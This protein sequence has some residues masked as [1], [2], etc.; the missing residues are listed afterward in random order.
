[1]TPFKI[2]DE[3]IAYLEMYDDFVI[4]SIK[5]GITFDVEELNWFVMILDKYYPNKKFGYI[6]NR[7]YDY[8]LN[9]T[10]YLTSSFHD[11]LSALAIV[12]YSEIG[13]ETAL[14]KK[15][16]FIKP[17]SVFDDIEEGKNWVLNIKKIA[18]L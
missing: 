5:D 11:R 15:S 9:P 3:D 18:G 7:I 6:S 10:T 12:Y 17:F 14:Y 1:M 4:S 16:F 2:I 13:R 8:S